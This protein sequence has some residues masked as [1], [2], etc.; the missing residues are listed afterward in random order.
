MVGD[1]AAGE[2]CRPRC[3]PH[4]YGVAA[5][6][7]IVNTDITPGSPRGTFVVTLEVDV[8]SFEFL[9]LDTARI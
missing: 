2:Q 1:D 7:L 6:L 4:N 5:A 8:G 9:Q 3:H